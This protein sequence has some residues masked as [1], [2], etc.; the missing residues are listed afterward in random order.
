MEFVRERLHL[1]DEAGRP[2]VGAD[3]FIALWR[4]TPGQLWLARLFSLPG[5]RQ[6]FRCC[7]NIFARQLYRWNRR[8]G[9]W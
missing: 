4:A 5:L 2:Q 9:H 1:V 7:Y 6:L 3:A 8:R